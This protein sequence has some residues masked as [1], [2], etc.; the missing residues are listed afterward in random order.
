MVKAVEMTAVSDVAK[1]YPSDHR[2]SQL[3]VIATLVTVRRDP[4]KKRSFMR[5]NAA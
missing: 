5:R 1:R 2:G 4:S 3:T